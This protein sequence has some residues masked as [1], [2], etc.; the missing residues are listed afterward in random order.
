MNVSHVLKKPIVTEKSLRRMGMSHYTFEVH[1]N[2]NKAEVAEA[3]EEL[4]DVTV[5]RVKIM[6]RKGKQKRTVGRRKTVQTSPKKIAIVAIDPK[7][8]IELFSEFDADQVENEEESDE[9]E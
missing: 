4:F 5:L 1:I 8:S 3:V 2:T 6:N 9:G 7:D